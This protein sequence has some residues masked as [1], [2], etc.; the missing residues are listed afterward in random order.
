[1]PRIANPDFAADVAASFDKQNA[2]HLILA[3]LA[4][5]EHGRT[6][7]HVAHWYGI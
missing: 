4:L 2:M 7:I 3:K 1:M 5:V 6:E